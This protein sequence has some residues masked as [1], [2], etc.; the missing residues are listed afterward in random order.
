[1]SIDKK[2]LVIS[3]KS[4]LNNVIK[5]LVNKPKPYFGFACVVNNKKQLKGVF[6]SGDLLRA[7]NQGF[8]TNC[9]ISEVMTKNPISIIES[10]LFDEFLEIKLNQ[11]LIK[12]FSP[13]KRY[14]KYLPVIDKDGIL[15]DILTYEELID[16]RRSNIGLISVWGLSLIHI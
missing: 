8:T 10:E 4:T 3:E 11:K 1:M 6:N 7:L 13:E 16:L 14:T 15:K 2:V 12:K 9:L 5:E